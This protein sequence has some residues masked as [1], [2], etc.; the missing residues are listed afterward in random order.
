MDLRA[1]SPI[2][3]VS[4]VRVPLLIAHG[5]ED[6]RVPAKQ[7]RMMMEALT[8]AG[9][10]VTSVFCKKGGHSFSSSEDFADWLRRLE[11]FLAK[12]NPA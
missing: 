3:F 5:E 12:H 9:G 4:K 6:E 11:A 10:N 8:K 1:V 2:S 7:S